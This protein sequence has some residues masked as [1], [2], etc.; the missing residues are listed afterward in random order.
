[1]C[2]GD[3]TEREIEEATGGL[4]GRKSPGSEGLA[5]VYKYIRMFL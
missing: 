5:G 1:M 4:Q 3:I 2:D